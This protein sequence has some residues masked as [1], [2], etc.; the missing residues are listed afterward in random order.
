MS[1]GFR[2]WWIVG[3][4][5]LAQFA[6]LGLSIIT[7]P[8][9][10]DPI[11]DEFAVSMMEFNLV[12]APFTVVMTLA[13]PIVGPMLD[14]YSI[15]AIMASGA[16]LLA[17]SLALMS[18]ATAPWQLGALFG[19]GV[20]LS[21]TLLGPLPA[22]TVVAKWFERQR[23]RA[24]GVVS[25]GPL[26]AALLLSLAAGALIE[27][28][29][30]R[31]TLRWFS[32]GA[33]LVVL[34]VW[35]VIRNRPE[36][37]G[38]EPDGGSAG[39]AALDHFAAMPAWSTRALLSARSFWALALALGLVFGFLQGWQLNIG[40]YGDDLGYGVQQ[41]SWLLVAAAALGI[42][43][44][45]LFGWLAERRD[46]R[47]LLWFSI[48]VQVTAFAVLRTRPD[49]L[50][51]LL[52]ASAALGGTGGGLMPLYAALLARSF[53]PASF[54]TAMGLA[55][56]VMLPF[57]ALAPPLLGQLRDAS[58]NY[59]SGLLLLIAALV[60]GAAILGFLPRRESAA[61]QA[62]PAG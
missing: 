7:Y 52:L 56:L 26:A 11:Q 31:A 39:G 20:A 22:T 44:T 19:M 51:V 29:G 27:S 49:Q 58:G 34:P 35:L 43:G 5:F 48:A 4:A 32:L 59:E 37:I 62:V 46:P 2:G 55:G 23:G 30:W 21:V 38:Q 50:Y 24:I 40:K 12:G 6:S 28:V 41:Q 60:V 36:D 53:G 10:A 3:V 9:F 45:V 13:G 8:L 14:R 15:R 57:G 18:F 54:G 42:P 17:A 33:L 61:A 47:L 1:S 16:L 25:L